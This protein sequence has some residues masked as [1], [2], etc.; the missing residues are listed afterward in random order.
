MP[1]DQRSLKKQTVTTIS[2]SL[3]IHNKEGKNMFIIRK[4]F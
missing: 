3:I 1:I 4:V 2:Y